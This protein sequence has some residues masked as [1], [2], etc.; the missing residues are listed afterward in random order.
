MDVV[1]SEMVQSLY[2][3]STGLSTYLRRA[4][5]LPSTGL[6]MKPF[7]LSAY[8]AGWTSPTQIQH[9]N[10]ERAISDGAQLEEMVPLA[11]ILARGKQELAT[12]IL[13]AILRRYTMLAVAAVSGAA[14][15]AR[16]LDHR[17]APS[18]LPSDASM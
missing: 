4:V 1:C 3:P 16:Q 14:L 10:L 12:A 2:L 8:D 18:T 13:R 5:Y 9:W 6:Q 7:R 15:L 11:R 17:L